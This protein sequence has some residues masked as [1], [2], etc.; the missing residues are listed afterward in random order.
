MH[1]SKYGEKYITFTKWLAIILLPLV[2]ILLSIV[3]IERK[4]ILDGMVFSPK[5]VIVRSPVNNTLIN[6]I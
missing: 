2:I 6:K 4:V 5:Q 1:D 3:E